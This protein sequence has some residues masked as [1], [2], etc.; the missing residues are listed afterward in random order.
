MDG[1]FEYNYV[2]TG[3]VHFVK[4]VLNSPIIT[5][6]SSYFFLAVLC[7]ASHVL[8]HTLRIIMTSWRID[9]FIICHTLFYP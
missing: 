5:V 2:L 7:F 6:D 8:T 3:S 9:P 1:A 4:G